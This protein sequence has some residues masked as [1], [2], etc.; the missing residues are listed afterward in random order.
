MNTS[1]RYRFTISNPER[2]NHHLVVS[3]DTHGVVIHYARKWNVTITEATQRMLD[4]A[5]KELVKEE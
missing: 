1:N 5:I 4:I 3:S 2:T